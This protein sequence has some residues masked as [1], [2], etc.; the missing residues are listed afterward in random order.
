MTWLAVL[1]YSTV[2]FLLQLVHDSQVDTNFFDEG[3][4]HFTMFPPKIISTGVLL[5]YKIPLHEV[6]E[7]ERVSVHVCTC[8]RVY[9]LINF[10]ISYNIRTVV[11]TYLRASLTIR[12]THNVDQPS[13]GREWKLPLIRRL[14]PPLT[15]TEPKLGDT[16]QLL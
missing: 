13:T 2:F 16:L 7:R 11:V 10:S 5:N 12:N 14:P 3:W 15:V 1:I 8:T 6:K 4:F 9:W